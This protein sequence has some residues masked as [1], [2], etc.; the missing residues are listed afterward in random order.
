MT[1][2]KYDG[3]SIYLDNKTVTDEY[4]DD[5]KIRIGVYEVGITLPYF[6]LRDFGETEEK[7]KYFL[8][9]SGYTTLK[10]LRDV[11]FSKLRNRHESKLIQYVEED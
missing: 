8:M 1:E 4:R 5:K 3:F 6:T 11:V 7:N 9:S 2:I 10:S